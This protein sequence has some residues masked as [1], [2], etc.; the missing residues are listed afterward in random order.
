MKEW[1]LEGRKINIPNTKSI[2]D[3]IGKSKLIQYAISDNL[4]FLYLYFIHI[5]ETSETKLF[6]LRNKINP[7]F[8]KLEKQD[9]ILEYGE[10]FSEKDL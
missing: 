9:L 4:K 2:G 6:L 10:E 7:F 3:P 1:F 5:D 8:S